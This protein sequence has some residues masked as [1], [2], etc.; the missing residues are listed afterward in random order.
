MAS[1]LRTADGVRVRA[2]ATVRELSGRNLGPETAKRFARIVNGPKGRVA[3]VNSGRRPIVVTLWLTAPS[4][5]TSLPLNEV[6]RWSV[7]ATTRS[8]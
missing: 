6:R 3:V 5:A 1:T 8:Q 4:T 2:R 7:R